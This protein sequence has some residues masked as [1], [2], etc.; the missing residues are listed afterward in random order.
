MSAQSINLKVATPYA[1]ALL[2]IAKQSNLLSLIT[3]DLS[4]VSSILLDSRDLQ[5]S[6]S[7][8]VIDIS[9]KKEILSQI[10]QSQV[11]EKVLKFLLV[12]VERR[13]ITLLNLIIDKYLD[14]AYKSQSTT[15]AEITT[16][17]AF[18]EQ[19]END[20]INKI[21]VM[22]NSE[23]VKLLMNIDSNLIAGFTIK[24]GSKIVDT[25]LSGKLNQMSLYLN[26][27]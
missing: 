11:H 12:L 5:A 17:V 14:L 25:S 13:R 22:T 16:C 1:E 4:L 18:N 15:I 2:D 23:N 24:I 20:L 7:N 26:A 19:Q 21:K 8:P 27:N 9:A 6:L 10:F 3:E